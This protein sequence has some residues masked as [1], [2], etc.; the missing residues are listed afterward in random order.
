MLPSSL[1][2]F[3]ATNCSHV[4][5]STVCDCCGVSCL[6]FEHRPIK[7]V[8]VLI[9]QCPEEDSKQ[10]SQIHVIGGFLKPQTSGVVKVHCKLGR[11]VLIKIKVK[12]E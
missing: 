9:V 2:H 10:L 1:P 5:C 11:E 4:C 12:G 3:S 6:L 8:V 7:Y